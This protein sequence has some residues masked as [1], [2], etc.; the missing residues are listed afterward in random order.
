MHFIDSKTLFLYLLQ[1]IGSGRSGVIMIENFQM[2]A[3]DT[4]AEGIEITDK[5][6]L[7]IRE[8]ILDVIEEILLIEK[9]LQM[10]IKVFIAMR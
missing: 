9:K 10:A 1:R 7:E 3:I 5:I 8:E 4:T 6:N 2:I